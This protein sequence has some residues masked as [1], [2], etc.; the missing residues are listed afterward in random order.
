MV[1]HFL[2]EAFAVGAIIAPITWKAVCVSL[3]SMSLFDLAA[4]RKSNIFYSKYVWLIVLVGRDLA[5]RGYK[6]VVFRMMY[7]E[8]CNAPQ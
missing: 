6:L 7:G 5:F 4:I 3:Q 2:G 8:L 1:C